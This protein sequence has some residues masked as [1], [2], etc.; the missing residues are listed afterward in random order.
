MADCV[1]A[2]DDAGNQVACSD[3]AASSC[4]D[5]S[6]NYVNCPNNNPYGQVVTTGLIGAS[7]L[8]AGVGGASA[9]DNSGHLSLTS[10]SAGSDMIGGIAKSVASIFSGVTAIVAPPKPVL[11]VGSSSVSNTGLF[12]NPMAL[13]FLGI[14]AY[15][16]FG[17]LKHSR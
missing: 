6:G 17:G 5:A 16:A 3:P 1:I 11:S 14:L 12:S 10:P 7:A 9:G 13:A 15:L 2:F 4:T 8:A